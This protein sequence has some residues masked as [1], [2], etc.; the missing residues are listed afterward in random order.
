M[1]KKN[2]FK[3]II[4]IT[5]LSGLIVLNKTAYDYYKNIEVQALPAEI[6]LADLYTF[7]DLN[8]IVNPNV[9]TATNEELELVASLYT[10]E[11]FD[12]IEQP[13]CSSDMSMKEC[14]ITYLDSP[15]DYEVKHASWFNDFYDYLVQERESLN[16]D[17]NLTSYYS[18]EISIL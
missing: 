8:I 17:E 1:S 14:A 7:D 12:I 11:F 5:L 6:D 18:E 4:I 15:E 9:A 3:K 2:L 13:M 10:V 16:N